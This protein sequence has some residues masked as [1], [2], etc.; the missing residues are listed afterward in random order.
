MAL[1]EVEA[2]SPAHHAEQVLRRLEWK[3]IRRLDGLLQGDYRTLL[4]GTGLDLADLR[5]YQLHDDV[6]HI[7][8]NV[9]A[10]MQSPHVRVFTEDR[11]MSAWFLL[12]LSPSID[13]GSGELRKRNV[14]AEF[15][16]VL[17]RLLTRHGNRVGAMLY[18]AGVDSIIPARN[19][20]RHVLHLL[21]SMLDRVVTTESGPTRLQELLAS[22]A[23]MIKRR[24]TIFVVSDFISEPGWEKALAQLAQRHEVVAVRVLDPLELDLPDLGLLT[25]R[26][27]ETGE[28]VVV[29]THDAGFRKRFAR[30]AA[31]REAELRE[32]LV[33]S[34]V[35]ALELS[36]DADLV[37][38]IVR[39]VDMRK[40]RTQLAS[41]GLPAHLRRAA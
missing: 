35:D 1:E 10:R 9:T 12:D 8:W 15:V 2:A 32:A 17:A 6:R 13:F 36:T 7:D 20:R 5:E 30:I 19:G 38:A 39:F 11:E 41:G 16:A 23:S 14:S 18:G 4:R 22:G 31:Q 25:L 3:V 33:R 27:A 21:H 26:D 37:D 29:D 40:R 24:S 28:Q 34:N